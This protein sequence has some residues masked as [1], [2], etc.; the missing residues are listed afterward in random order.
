VKEARRHE[1]AWGDSMTTA[2]YDITFTGRVQGVGFRWTTCRV[3]QRFGVSGWVRN[4]SDGAV[5][6]VAEGETGDLDAFVKDVQDAM[7][8]YIKDTRI[9]R[10]SAHGDL[11]GFRIR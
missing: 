5:R 10:T 8:G 7:D 4:E 1:V 11:N 3:A 2:R 9:T 6:C